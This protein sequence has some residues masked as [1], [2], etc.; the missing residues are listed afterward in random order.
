MKKFLQSLAK[1]HC[2]P[3]FLFLRLSCVNILTA[4]RRLPGSTLFRKRRFLIRAFLILCSVPYIIFP[5][6]FDSILN[7]S[8]I[9]F[10]AFRLCIRQDV[11]H[12]FCLF[13]QL[14]IPAV[15]LFLLRRSQRLILHLQLH[16]L[17]YILSF[18][19]PKDK[20]ITLL[21]TFCRHACFLVQLRQF[22]SPF[23]N[24]FRLLILLK[25]FDLLL[26]RCSLRTEN[27]ISQDILIRVFR[28]DLNKIVIIIDRFI[29]ISSFNRQCTKAADDL[30]A[31]LR[32]A[33]SKIQ[34]LISLLILFILFIDL[35]D[36][37]QHSGISD[38]LPVDQVRDFRCLSV[39]TVLHK[40][41]HL[42]GLYFIIILIHR[43]HLI[44]NNIENNISSVSYHLPAPSGYKPIFF[45]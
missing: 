3:D 23:F 1:R 18:A 33:V 45:Q 29:Y 5:I 42:F 31:P 22:I 11:R 2:I 19:E 27:L 32:T 30:P 36:I 24:I 17:I 16:R 25:R 12:F 39:C 26:D 10:S 40:F 7:I 9:S 37:C 38:P 43:I 44:E 8:G 35:T 14:L 20:I 4:V 6:R 41:E 28:R 21:Q 15:I 13:R 34:H